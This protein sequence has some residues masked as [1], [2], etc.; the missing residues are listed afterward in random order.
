LP[1]ARPTTPIN[2]AT[3]YRSPD[4]S[5]LLVFSRRKTWARTSAPSMTTSAR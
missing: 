2:C 1:N 3:F 5:L 4:Q